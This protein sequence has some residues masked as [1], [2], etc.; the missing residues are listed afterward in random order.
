M[1]TEFFTRYL[2]KIED[3]TD[4]YFLLDEFTKEDAMGMAGKVKIQL[5]DEWQ[6]K[7]RLI[8]YLESVIGSL[9]REAL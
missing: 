5:L 4:N 7:E 2:I 1:K 3:G 9:K 8:E 6:S